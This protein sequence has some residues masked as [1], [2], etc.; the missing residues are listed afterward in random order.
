MLVNTSQGKRRFERPGRKWENS[1]VYREDTKY[2]NVIWIQL[3]QDMSQCRS[4]CTVIS[5]PTMYLELNFPTMY[6]ESNFPTI[7][8]CLHQ[9]GTKAYGI[10]RIEKR[11]F[12]IYMYSK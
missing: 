6:L 10:L 12:Q 1:K 7:Y 2:D 3:A 8:L 5:F 11:K 4:I 9:M